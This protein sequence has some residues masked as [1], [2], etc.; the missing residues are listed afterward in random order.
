M[1]QLYEKIKLIP[2]NSPIIYTTKKNNIK[3]G[4]LIKVTPKYFIR[5]NGNKYR[6]WYKNIN[7]AGLNLQP[8]GPPYNLPEHILKKIF[9]SENIL[10]E[11][12]DQTHANINTIEYHNIHITSMG[13]KYGKVFSGNTWNL[14]LIE[15]L[16]D[17]LIENILEYLNNMK[18][19]Y[20]KYAYK[21]KIAIEQTSKEHYITCDVY[22]KREWVLR[23]KEII[24]QIRLK[25]Y[26]I[27]DTVKQTEKMV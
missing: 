26:N 12:I 24:E 14:I 9:E 5:E 20:M 19:K 2:I 16:V 10:N 1:M 4:K 3:S 15:E 23:K 13:G 21:V 11:F 25:M 8:F 22:H 6:V 27:R 7:K 17:K 18:G